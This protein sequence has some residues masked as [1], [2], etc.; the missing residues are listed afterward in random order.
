MEIRKLEKG[1]YVCLYCGKDIENDD[2][3]CDCPDAIEKYRI[4]EEIRVL[5]QPLKDSIPAYKYLIDE[6]WDLHKID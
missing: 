1:I 2:K 3:K 6:K 4:I 5:T